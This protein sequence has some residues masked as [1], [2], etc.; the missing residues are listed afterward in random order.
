MIFVTRFFPEEEVLAVREMLPLPS[1][2]QFSF[3]V[4]VTETPFLSTSVSTFV[5]TGFA[6]SFP[7]GGVTGATTGAMGDVQPA[8]EEAWVS[9]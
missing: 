1:S 6:M 5:S 7:G 9:S 2:V 4:T 3:G 8:V